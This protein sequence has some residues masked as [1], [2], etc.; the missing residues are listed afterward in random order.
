MTI[1]AVVVGLRCRRQQAKVEA[2][3]VAERRAAERQAVLRANAA[4]EAE[5]Q[6]QRE[7]SLEEDRKIAAY[8]AAEEEKKRCG[9]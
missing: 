9:S 4:A 2:Q 3:L 5:R 6:R 7:L 8:I 1:V